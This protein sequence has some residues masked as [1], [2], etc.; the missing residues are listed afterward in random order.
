MNKTPCPRCGFPLTP[1]HYSRHLRVC[2]R[3]PL[4]DE[5]RRI[6]PTMTVTEM[7]NLWGVNHGTVK[8]RL[9][10]MGIA[11]GIDWRRKPPTPEQVAQMMELYDEGVPVQ[12][13]AKLVGTVEGRTQRTI[14][15]L[16]DEGKLTQREKPRP[17]LIIYDRCSECKIRLDGPDVP[18]GEGGRCGFCARPEPGQEV[19]A[20]NAILTPIRPLSR[21]LEEFLGFEDADY[22]LGWLGVSLE[23]PWT[24][25]RMVAEGVL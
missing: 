16:V 11:P 2:K 22:W 14:L 9:D 20:T 1:H 10:W 18:T 12:T 21:P 4:D 3:I 23:P 24:W 8:A 7:G 19:T 6:A 5:L 17:P 15:R 25:G 13:I